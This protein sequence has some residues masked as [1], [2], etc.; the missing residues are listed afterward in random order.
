MS[1]KQNNQDQDINQNLINNENF[2]Q[3]EKPGFINGPND[4]Y[5][6]QAPPPQY[7]NIN[8]TQNCSINDENQNI[9]PK[10]DSNNFQ[11]YNQQNPPTINNNPQTIINNQYS[12]YSNTNNFQ[13]N[14]I[15]IPEPYINVQSNEPIV[16]NQYY[17]NNMQKPYINGPLINPQMNYGVQYPQQ[18]VVQQ[19][20]S[21]NDTD[22]CCICG[23]VCAICFG[24][25]CVVGLVFIGLII[26]GIVSFFESLKNLD[27]GK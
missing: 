26:Y 20:N 7:I 13:T 9:T 3:I 18:N 22:C 14:N 10:E 2:N 19:S 21:N 25:V 23:G 8:S 11:K 6:N 17:N 24:S 4:T 12:N 27:N 1:E 16:I 5:Q 15:N